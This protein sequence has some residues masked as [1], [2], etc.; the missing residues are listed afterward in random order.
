MRGVVIGAGEVG[1]AV[2]SVLVDA[3]RTGLVDKDYDVAPAPDDVEII[4]VCFPWGDWFDQE[5]EKYRD[6]YKP[7]YTVIHSTVPV[8]TS[9]RLDAI[10]SP[11]RGMHPNMEEGLRRFVKFVGGPAPKSDAVVDYLRRAGMR[12]KLC[13]RS[14]TTELAKLMST[15][16][17][18]VCI[19]FVK[20]AERLCGKHGAPFAEA[21][22]LW[23]K[24]YNEGYRDILRPEYARP[25]L[26]PI[27]QKIGGHCVRENSVLLDSK[28]SELVQGE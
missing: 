9:S 12:V 13:R 24:T 23:Q 15:L 3:Y 27:Q 1:T 10:H 26:E 28:F 7:K 25:V 6:Q 4:H 14:E 8:G 2:H 18:G 5:I 17:Y 11:V 19:E 20:E 21:F 22:T 16:Y